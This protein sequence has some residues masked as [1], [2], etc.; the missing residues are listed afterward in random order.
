MSTPIPPP[1]PPQPRAPVAP[2]PPRT[3]VKK[4]LVTF[5]VV[6]NLVVFGVLGAVWLAAQ[7]VSGAVSTIPASDLTLVD[8]PASL[9]EPRVLLLIGSDSRENLDDLTNF[10][11]FGGQRADVIILVKVDPR[12]DRLQMLSIPRDLKIVHNGSTTRINATFSDGPAGIVEAVKNFTGS[13]IH[14]YLQVEFSGFSGIV[15][16]IGGI[17]MTFPYPARDTRSGFEVN[18]G[19][20]VLDGRNALAYARSRYYQEYRNGGW[21]SVQGTDINRTRRQQDVL[22]AILTQVDR[23]SSISGFNQLLDAL[24]GFVVTDEGFDEEEILQLAWEM[25][26]V[27]SDDLDALTLPVRITSESGTSYVVPVEPDA[28]AAVSAF[29]AGQRMSPDVGL[30]AA[31]EVQNG[32]GRPG[33]AG[34]I[35]SLLTDGGFNVVGTEDSARADYEVTQV[36]VRPN[37][38]HIAQD[39]ADHLGFGEAVVGGTPEGVDI[40]VIVG[41]DAPSV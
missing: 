39:I 11:A 17:E 37:L 4:A 29:L 38:L 30:Q 28:S 15:D 1:L 20:Q 22:M 33:S 13:P 5:L 35:A 21:V 31:I 34:Q 14:H 7:R 2:T 24:G 16:A 27:G 3:W 40:V 12:N 32:N 8:R 6:A 9:T 19:R 23:P 26:N 36:I 10:G 41:L 25:R 18:A